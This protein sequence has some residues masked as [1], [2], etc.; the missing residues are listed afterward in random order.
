MRKKKQFFSDDQDK[1]CSAVPSQATEYQSRSF[2][3][4]K[5]LVILAKSVKYGQYCIAGREVIRNERKLQ[6]GTWI[7]P[8]SDHDAGALSTSDIM[9]KNGRSPFLLDIIQ[10]DVIRNINN[11]TQPENWTVNKSTWEKTGRMRIESIFQQVIET[12]VS[13]WNDDFCQSDRITTEEYIRN[14]YNSSLCI[15]QPK[16]F[17]MEISTVYNEF[18]GRKK[19]RRRGKFL[20][21]SVHYDLAITDPDIDR[22]YFRP[23]PGIN[24]G[25]RK[26]SMD[27]TKCLLCISLA[28]EFNGYHYKLIA[29]VI[30]NG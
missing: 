16:Y 28:P 6:L 21:N 8:I 19:K 12:P 1:H 17:V 18:E 29:T 22:K 7:R 26:I 24:D 30:E 5:E 27:V 3:T 23:F 15:I 14:Y 9:L 2:A 25:I 20:Y 10:I 11:P 4:R 13:L